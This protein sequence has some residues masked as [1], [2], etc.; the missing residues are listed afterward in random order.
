MDERKERILKAIIHDY[1]KTAEPVS[2]RTIARKHD[3]GV[4]PATVR[5]EMSDLKEMGYLEQPH[6]SSGR[7]PSAQGY[8]FYVDSMLCR[9]VLTS[10]DAALIQSLWDTKD[11]DIIACMQQTAKLISRISHN[12]SMVL[13]PT[14][15]R[16]RIRYVHVLPTGEQR[17]I[18]VAVTDR[19]ALDNEPIFF[20]T[21]PS[22]ERLTH[23]GEVLQNALQGQLLQDITIE[24]L[25]DILQQT[26]NNDAAG[27]SVC[28]ALYRAITKRKIAYAVGTPELLDQP[29]F[30]EKATMQPILN[31]LEE[32]E[33]LSRLLVTTTDQPVTVRI[34]RENYDA[35]M[36]NC[37][38]IQADFS[39]GD[40]KLGTLAIL[41]PT[42]MEYGRIVGML[43][44]MQH[45]I[46]HMM[47]KE[48]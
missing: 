11:P 38:L 19:G 8:R 14:A 35:K 28:E 31:L 1:V 4:S 27:A 6:T 34:G 43:T 47:Q 5:N 12:M 17:A 10:Q 37:S 39:A 32:E 13:A 30:Q 40:E 16:S 3:L 42:R 15:N 26:Q 2:S 22:F 33:E 20:E 7:V 9:E 36:H 21:P 18:L 24:Y 46:D 25:Q 23:L 48:K 44:Y 41:G 45:L 29:E